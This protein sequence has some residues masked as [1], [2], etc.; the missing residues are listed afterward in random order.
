[1]SVKLPQLILTAIR[2]PN[3]QLPSWPDEAP[4][5]QIHLDLVVSDLVE[6]QRHAVRLGARLVDSQPAPG[7]CRVLL[8]PA[9]HPFCLCLPPGL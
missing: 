6:A 4:P 5:K 9:G 3:Y 8:D 2:V 7:K 1:M